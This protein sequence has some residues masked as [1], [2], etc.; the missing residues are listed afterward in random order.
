V[1]E[2]QEDGYAELVD[3]SGDEEWQAT[4][5]YDITIVPADLV[6]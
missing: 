6:D 5:P 3:V 2:V 1:G 4:Q